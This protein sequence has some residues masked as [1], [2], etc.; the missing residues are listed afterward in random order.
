M[1]LGE[2]EQELSARGIAVVVQNLTRDCHR[3]KA[4]QHR[5]VDGRFGVTTALEGPTRGGAQREHVAGATELGGHSVAIDDAPDRECT[6]GRADP[7][8]CVDVV[9]RDREGGIATRVLRRDHR[10][11]LQPVDHSRCR[12]H[13]DETAR[14][15]Q[16]EVECVGGYPARRHLEV[17]LVL[18]VLVVDDEDH[19]ATSDSFQCLIDAG[20]RHELPFELC[21]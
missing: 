19:L 3:W 13:A 11:K 1:A 4:G 16:H 20:E 14:P 5:Q 6:V 12:G 7:A 9:D 18:A 17:A 8:P 15:A 21:S 2:R 10:R